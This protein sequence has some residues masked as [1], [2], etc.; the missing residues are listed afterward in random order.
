MMYESFKKLQNFRVLT[1]A[2][3]ARKPGLSGAQLSDRL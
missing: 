2:C 3:P 1:L